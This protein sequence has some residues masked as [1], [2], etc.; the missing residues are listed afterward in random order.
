VGLDTV[1]LIMKAEKLFGIKVP[2]DLAAKTETVGQFVNLIYELRLISDKPLS[3]DEIL[4]QLRQMIF[5][6]F[7]LPMER[8][9]PEASFT[10]DL[11]LD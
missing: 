5:K 11:G 4:L 3:Y 9:I 1:E 6:N 10:K 7:A 8:I 2:D